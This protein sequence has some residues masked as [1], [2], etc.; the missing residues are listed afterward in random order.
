MAN[1]FNVAKYILDTVGGEISAMKL[2]KLCYYSQSWNL[3]WTG[4]P[5][6]EE[7]FLRWE[8]GPVC[9]ELF[10]LHQGLFY[11]SADIIP[12]SL[13]SADMLEDGY[14]TVNRVMENYGRFS[15]DQLSDM[16]HTEDPWLNTPE[17]AIITKESMELY[18]GN[19]PE[20]EKYDDPYFKSPEYEKDVAKAIVEFEK[21]NA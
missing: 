18:Y 15:G 10:D 19:L 17:D 5:I 6:F 7:D 3:A 11:I 20:A 14:R 16:T 8:N 4:Y 13:L 21:S 12:E 9:R 2:Q 1:I